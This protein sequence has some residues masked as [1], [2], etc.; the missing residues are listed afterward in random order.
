MAVN[1]CWVG[2]QHLSVAT[3]NPLKESGKEYVYTQNN[4][5]SM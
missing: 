4:T 3:F 2:D 1:T 5:V